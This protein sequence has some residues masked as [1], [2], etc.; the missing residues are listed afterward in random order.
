M[1]L[2]FNLSCGRR[3]SVCDSRNIGIYFRFLIAIRKKKIFIVITFHHSRQR[4]FWDYNPQVGLIMAGG[5]NP[6]S[7]SVT[8]S[9]D[10]GLS[11]ETLTDIPYACG[12]TIHRGCLVIMN[13][14]TVFVAGGLSEYESGIKFN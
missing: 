9:Q 13:T 14:T 5:L 2:H 12:S 11:V 1:G 10:F 4:Q 6:Q 3:V 7:I 8:R